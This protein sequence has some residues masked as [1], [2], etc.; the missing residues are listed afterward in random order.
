MRKDVRN[1]GLTQCITILQVCGTETC[2]KNKPCASIEK[3]GHWFRAKC[4]NNKCVYGSMGYPTA[5]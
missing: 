4:Q 3:N 1:L 2:K 5:H